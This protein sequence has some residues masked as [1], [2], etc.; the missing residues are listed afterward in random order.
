MALLITEKDLK[1]LCDAEDFVEGLIEV[2]EAALAETDPPDE[3]ASFLLFPSGG[4]D[5]SVQLYPLASRASGCF[6]RIG[7][8]EASRR[9][10]D[11]SVVVHLDRDDGRVLAV[12][13]TDSLA[14]WRTAA[15]VVVAAKHLA[16]PGSRVVAM[17]G[18]GEQ[19]RYQLRGLVRVLPA[20]ESVRV[21]SRT[22]AS[23]AAFVNDI[24][25]IVRAQLSA[26]DS[27]REACAGADVVCVTAAAAEPVA[28]TSWL[29]PGALITSI[30]PLA[31]HQDAPVRRVAPSRARPSVRPSGWDPYPM[32]GPSRVAASADVTLGDVLR[33]AT[34]PAQ[35]SEAAL[36]LQLGPGP[37]DARLLRWAYEWA[38]GSSVGTTFHLSDG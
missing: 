34:A 2:V 12:M 1:P 5:R 4:G 27:A 30:N 21:Y 36:Y 35:K 13:A 29:R 15:P 7:P 18:S 14:P 16:D 25:P 19:A 23:R 24:S 8:S 28:S 32:E 37:W 6:V 3:H 33:G 10:R 17:I 26:V 11:T 22:P 38:L 9:A 20:L 31:V